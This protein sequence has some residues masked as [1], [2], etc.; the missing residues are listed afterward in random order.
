MTDPQPPLETAV[1]RFIRVFVSSTFRDMAEEREELI[2]RI[3]PQLRKLCESRGVI[4]GEVDLRWGIPDEA[5][6]EGKV[7]PI[8]LAEIHR[9]RPYFIG[10]L[11]ERYG[12]VPDEIPPDLIAREPW[13]KEHLYRSVT[14]LEILHGVL[15]YPE[16][17][18]HTFFYFRDPAYTD[19][20]DPEKRADFAEIPTPEE[21]SRFGPEEARRRAEARRGKLAALKERIRQSSLPLRENYLDPRDLGQLVLRDLTGVINRLF[22][23]G[24]QLTPLAREA[25]EHEAYAR[26]RAVVEVRPGEFSGVYVGREDYLERL[27][28]HVWGDGPPLVVLGESGMGKSA[29]LANWAL[30]YRASFTQEAAPP[31]TPKRSFWGKLKN[32]ITPATS[33]PADAPPLLIMH[34]IGAGPHSADWAAMLRRLMGELKR[35]FDIQQEI[36]DQPDALR[37]AFANFLSMAA[38][39]GRVILIIDAL[40]Q[41]EDRDAAPDL[42]WLPPVIPANVRLILSTLPGRPLDDLTRRGWLTLTVQP[43][44]PGERR[45]LIRAYLAQY[46]KEL[47]PPELERLAAA[48]PTANPLYL[49]ALLEELRVYGDHYTLKARL[50]HYLTAPGVKELYELILARYEGDYEGDRPGLVEEA[51]SLIGAARRGLSQAELLD[52]LGT[53]GEPLPGAV[54]SPLYLAAEHALMDRAG[55][56][57]FGHDYFRHAV[58]DRYLATEA[59]RQATHLRLAAYFD[60][61]DLEIG[62]RPN[63]RKIDE[64][65]WQL[66]QA[67]AWQRLYNLLLAPAFFHGAWK[68]DQFEVKTYWSKIENNSPFCLVEAY[69]GVLEAPGEHDPQYLLDLSLLLDD[70]GYPG[71][72][73]RLRTHLVEHYRLAGDLNNLSV[74]LGNQALILSSQGNMDGAMALHQE[75]ERLCRELGDKL[76]LEASLGNQANILYRRG[77][78]DRAL[79]L[80]QESERLCRELEHKNGL[81]RSLGN[82]AVVFFVQGNLDRAMALHKETER[83]WRELGNKKELT[84][85]LGNQAVILSDQGNLDVAMAL[86]QEEEGLCRELGDK[87]G[88]KASLGNQALII[89]GQGD[90][91]LA[92]AL[93]NEVERLCRELGDKQG[94]EQTIGNQAVII[95]SQGDLDRAMD[96]HQEEERLCRELGDKRGLQGSLGNQANILYSRGD[97]D[98]AMAL[99]RE[100]ERLCRELGF[101][102]G[103]ANSLGGRAVILSDWGDLEGAIDL[104]QEEE[105]IFR[106]LKNKEGLARSLGNQVGI[107]YG[108]GDFDRALALLQEGERLCRELGDKK[109]LARSLANQSKLMSE[110]GKPNEALALA[111]EAYRLATEHGYATL[112]GQI[113]AILDLVRG[114]IRKN[115]QKKKRPRVSY[116]AGGKPICP[117][118]KLES[119]PGARVCKWCKA[120]F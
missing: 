48:P 109:D 13:L 58:Q 97:L 45:Q 79:A 89:Y 73:L 57:S 53:E 103:L 34:Y 30:R 100:K 61:Q 23:E 56:I 105:R 38:A 24:S 27:N 99:Y 41:L 35:R 116:S 84:S 91:D 60:R 44:D 108:Q 76:G 5:K 77:D 81:A 1:P 113:K 70:T 74:S 59:T 21:I 36:P 18:D 95:Y 10:L 115:E 26:S 98:G 31:P 67:A 12:W 63:L 90:L 88:L 55:L 9:C 32:A 51:M 68:A 52:L 4:W 102:R 49:R 28:A 8:C 66:A 33:F 54:W 17:A 75:E 25:A 93:F 94:M 43:L 22:P 107:L 104:H 14:E 78:L 112:A 83:L 3:F 46:T 119:P 42:V 101:K 15:N 118:C 20:L 106:E 92:L 69:Q 114:T 37:L 7:L 86:H 80:H 82:Q 85:C 47:S 87:R 11:G 40:N 50:D 110:M 16:M 72:A 71:E 96:L 29:L 39:R 19:S 2:K 62:D 111:Q 64:L 65:P 117:V 120:A 6:A